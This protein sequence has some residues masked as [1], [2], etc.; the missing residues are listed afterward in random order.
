MCACVC[1]HLCVYVC[2]FLGVCMCL[3]KLLY[4]T[5]Q[6]TKCCAKVMRIHERCG[7][8]LVFLWRQISSHFHVVSAAF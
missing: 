2:F 5:E 7:V 4:V 8:F 1:G 6:K 3:C